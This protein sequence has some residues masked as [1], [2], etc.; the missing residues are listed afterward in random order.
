MTTTYKISRKEAFVETS[1]LSSAFQRM[2]QEPVSKQKNLDKIYELVV[3]NH[4]F[5]SSLASFSTYIQNNPTTEATLKFKKFISQIDKNLE[6]VLLALEGSKLD[7]ALVDRQNGPNSKEQL[8]TFVPQR[9]ELSSPMDIKLE[10][11][12]QEAHLV[13]EQ[14]QWLY[15]LSGKMLRLVS[16]IEFD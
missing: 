10:R 1:N 5:L 14:L 9:I 8:P 11:E 13:T 2:A 6:Q 16:K 7:Q 15:S 4:T 3:L 12:L